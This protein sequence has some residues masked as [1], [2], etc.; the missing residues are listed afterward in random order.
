M[1]LAV[2]QGPVRLLPLRG[3]HTFQLQP[4]ALLVVALALTPPLLLLPRDHLQGTVFL[5]AL[6]HSMMVNDTSV[7]LAIL[8]VLLQP[9]LARSDEQLLLKALLQT[10]QIQFP[11]QTVL[12]TIRTWDY[13]GSQAQSESSERC[14]FNVW[15][16]EAVVPNIPLDIP[17]LLQ[18]AS[19]IPTLLLITEF[20]DLSASSCQTSRACDDWNA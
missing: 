10:P 15:P 2:R 18:F 13:A 4:Q 7:N 17:S 8:L 14:F 5:S 11:M 20:H 1:L 12:K 6:K 16:L 9:P 19:S 3:P